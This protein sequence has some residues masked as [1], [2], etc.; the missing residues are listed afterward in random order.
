M[1]NKKIS[2]PWHFQNENF[3]TF[4]VCEK[5]MVNVFVFLNGVPFTKIFFIKKVA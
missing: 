5:C 1:Y 2:N 4:V 3:I